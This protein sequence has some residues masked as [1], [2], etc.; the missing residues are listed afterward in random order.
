MGGGGHAV[1]DLGNTQRDLRMPLDKFE[2]LKRSKSIRSVTH[3]SCVFG[4]SSAWFHTT[5]E[6]IT[7]LI[8]RPKPLFYVNMELDQDPRFS[9]ICD[10]STLD[11][12]HH[13]PCSGPSYYYDNIYTDYFVQCMMENIDQVISKRTY[14]T[15]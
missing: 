4:L 9:F 12:R 14:T 15:C 3:D 6:K 2:V 11:H 8:R 10:S 13:A 5:G 7:R 1:A